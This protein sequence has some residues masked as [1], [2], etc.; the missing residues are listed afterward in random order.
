[1]VG[2]SALIL[3]NQQSSERLEQLHCQDKEQHKNIRKALETA[4]SV[5]SLAT[6]VLLTTPAALLVSEPHLG[7]KNTDCLVCKHSC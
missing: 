7:S 1:M 2:S 5:I 3:L 4:T 6:P